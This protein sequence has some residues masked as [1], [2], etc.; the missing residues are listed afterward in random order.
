M[1]TLKSKT[2][3][4]RANGKAG[5]PTWDIAQ[6]FPRQG[7]WSVE[8]YLEL[9][10]NRQIELSDGVLE[11]LPLPTTLHQWIVLYLWESLKQFAGGWSGLGLALTSALPVRLWEGKFRE[12]DVIFLLAE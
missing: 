4:A 8:E 10:T 3:R 5:E 7:H 12:P 9:P 2:D 1:T 6:L 11:I